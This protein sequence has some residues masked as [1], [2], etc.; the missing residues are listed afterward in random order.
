MSSY[1][2]V[3]Y[4][5]M[6]IKSKAKDILLEKM[7]DDESNKY[8]SANESRTVSALRQDMMHMLTNCGQVLPVVQHLHRNS[9]DIAASS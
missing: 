3:Y 2:D 8:T 4:G 9:L 6:D 7:D 5:A 1:A